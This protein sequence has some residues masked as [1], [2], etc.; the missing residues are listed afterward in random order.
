MAKRLELVTQQDSEDIRGYPEARE[1]L[2]YVLDTLADSESAGQSGRLKGARS[3]IN[4]THCEKCFT[5]LTS[6]RKHLARSHKIK[7]M[8]AMEI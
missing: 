6:L 7:Q 3:R 2:R 1:Q 4:A 8:A 5:N